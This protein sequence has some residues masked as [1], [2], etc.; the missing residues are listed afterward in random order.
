MARLGK[1]RCEIVDVAHRSGSRDAEIVVEQE[2]SARSPKHINESRSLACRINGLA[3]PCLPAPAP[4]L[5]K[6]QCA[7]NALASLGKPSFNL[8][9]PPPP[10][11]KSPIP[12]NPALRSQIGGPHA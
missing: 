10:P 6:K 9:P 11:S 4:C 5:V 8:E 1:P 12:P 3:A 7:D 2:G